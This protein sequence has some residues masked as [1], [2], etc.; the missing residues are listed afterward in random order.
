MTLAEAET[1]AQMIGWGERIVAAT[2]SMTSIIQELLD[3]ARLQT[4]RVLQLNVRQI[5]LHELVNRCVAEHED[6]AD[7]VRVVPAAEP[8]RGWWDEARLLRVL[9]NLLDNALK[10]SAADRAV[11]IVLTRSDGWAIVRV[12]DDGIG[13]PPDELG[14]VFE[15]FFRGTNVAA[16]V[17]GSGIGLSVARQV[18]EQHGGSLSIQSELGAG[19]LVTIRLPVVVT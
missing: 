7:R 6:A 15:P 2:S 14:S 9:N 10:Y 16:G 1:A 3:V 5:D 4:G 11:E 19:C 12:A 8:I 17:N 18:V 13:I